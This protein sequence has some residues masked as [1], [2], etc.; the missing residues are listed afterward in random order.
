M[1]KQCSS[2]LRPISSY[3]VQYTQIKQLKQKKWKKDMKLTIKFI[4]S[5]NSCSHTHT[6]TKFTR[7]V[8]KKNVYKNGLELFTNIKQDVKK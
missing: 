3:N 2:P 6:R 5:M 7:V 1:K 4:Q 8:G